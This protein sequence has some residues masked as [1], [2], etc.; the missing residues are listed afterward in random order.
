MMDILVLL[1]LKAM[2]VSIA[3]ILSGDIRS[4]NLKHP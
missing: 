2:L 3:V 4:F 1:L